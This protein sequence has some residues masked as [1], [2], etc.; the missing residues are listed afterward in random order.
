[1]EIAVAAASPLG[2]YL[3][4][5]DVEGGGESMAQLL[6]AARPAAVKRPTRLRASSSCSWR[7]LIDAL[8]RRVEL[9]AA[10][11]LIPQLRAFHPT[12][13]EE[14]QQMAGAD[15]A[16]FA[17]PRAVGGCWWRQKVV[18]VELLSVSGVQ[19]AAE[20]TH[21]LVAAALV[22]LVAVVLLARRENVGVLAGW[23]CAL[24]GV[25]VAGPELGVR[26]LLAWYARRS[27]KLV[28]SLNAFGSALGKFNETYDNSLV[29][30]KRA[31]LASRGYR[32][33]AGLLPPIGRLEAEVSGHGGGEE[34]AGLSAAKQRLRCLPLRRRL[35]AVNDKLH[36]ETTAFS[37]NGERKRTQETRSIE[38]RI[39]DTA[40]AQ[41]P[42]LLLTALA[43][44]HNRAVLLLESAMH[45]VLVRNVARA[46]S[47]IDGCS[48]FPTLAS[49]RAAVDQLVGSLNTWTADLDAWNTT[50]D[51]VKLVPSPP[52]SN[53]LE[54]QHVASSDGGDI[55]LKG[56]STKLQ[57]LRS[58]S[59]T[60]SALVIAAQYEMVADDSAVERLVDSRDAMQAMVQHLQDAWNDYDSALSAL[61]GQN[62]T[63]KGTNGDDVEEDKDPESD[64]AAAVVASSSVPTSED[65][66]Y[67]VIFTGTSIGDGGFDLQ[68]LLRQHEADA[69]A[70]SSPTPYFV[71]EL[72][73]VL[74]H[75]QAQA[76]P[77]L[78]K[79][80]D[81]DPPVLSLSVATTL[82][83]TAPAPPPADAMFSLPRVPPR[84]R[85]RRQPPAPLG[86]PTEN[87]RTRSTATAFNSELQALL[88]RAQPIQ[89]QD[90]L[91][92]LGDSERERQTG[93]FGLFSD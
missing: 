26:G 48:L 1:M 67:T 19:V 89:Q 30:V 65:P 28:E 46:C 41:S 80:I 51:P 54:R 93:L 17:E 90:I 68:A 43:K 2:Q 11:R 7:Q 34:T 16:V 81:H 57:G 4:E 35:R 59:E 21:R 25:L 3:A 44:Q 42:S 66:N 14:L 24:A 87:E 70:T 33:G 88:Q 56:V 37:Q 12:I 29:L 49:H 18:V 52:E 74:A 58:M 50:S 76:Q 20:E 91:E 63:G 84:G 86:S 64:L 22:V 75:R 38:E 40:D 31:E 13:R 55:R 79:Q 69:S 9:L 27:R 77:G 53:T 83:S 85:P 62:D 5:L 23:S 8:R 45:S 72:R 10:R 73:D 32:L 39:N 92:S 15:A 60:L 36:A 78:T 61:C 82:L 71:R 47:S 6:T